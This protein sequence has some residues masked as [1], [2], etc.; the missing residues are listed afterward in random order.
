MEYYG[1]Q[2]LSIYSKTNECRDRALEGGSGV[3]RTLR[4]TRKMGRTGK[5]RKYRVN[6]ETELLAVS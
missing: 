5:M 4:L 2:G 1:A 6:R 3:I